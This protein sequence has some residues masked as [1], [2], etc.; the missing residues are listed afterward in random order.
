ML[1]HL[2]APFASLPIR[3]TSKS[4][5][6]FPCLLYTSPSGFWHIFFCK[7]LFCH[8]RSMFNPA[9][10][11]NQKT[12]H[13]TMTKHIST[14]LF[15][16]NISNLTPVQ[17]QIQNTSQIIPMSKGISKLCLQ[18]CNPNTGNGICTFYMKIL[19]ITKS[20]R[21]DCLLYTSLKSLVPEYFH[22]IAAKAE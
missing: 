17:S 8:H 5:T 10:F 19:F 4:S 6:R 13:R 9:D 12:A 3:I 2:V 16:K 20:I 11:L 22:Q 15:Q 7:N 14:I 21:D 1:I 18:G